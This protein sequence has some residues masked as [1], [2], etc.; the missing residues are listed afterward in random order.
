MSDR[1]GATTVG[2][3]RDEILPPLLILAVALIL[4]EAAVKSSTFRLVAPAPTDIVD[5]FKTKTLWY[6]TGF[7][8]L[9]RCRILISAV[10]G[11][12]YR[13]DRPFPLSRAGCVPYVIVSCHPDHRRH[14]LAYD[15]VRLRPRTQDHDLCHHFVSPSS[16]TRRA[17]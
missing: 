2:W 5:R 1:D 16:P 4:W 3:L 13:P 12:C 6:H 11:V 15:L 10:L 8:V 9:R 14:S 17:G 7:T